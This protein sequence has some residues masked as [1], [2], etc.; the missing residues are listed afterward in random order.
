M[1][2]KYYV[3]D[4]PQYNGDHEVHIESC[5]YFPKVK[6]KTY[7]GD[8]ETCKEAVQVAKQTHRRA[9]GCVHC[10]RPCHMY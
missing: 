10:C 3:N 4:T 7:L 8:Y 5:P 6:N 2:L 1:K 9:N